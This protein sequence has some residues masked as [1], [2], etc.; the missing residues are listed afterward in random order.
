[1]FSSLFRPSIEKLI[2]KKDVKG[3]ISALK[4][5]DQKYVISAIQALG[6][7]K[8][9]ESIDAL[10]ETWNN[11]KD[12]N[13]RKEIYI[14][15]GKI[16]SEKAIDILGSILD[17]GYGYFQDNPEFA[18]ISA[19]YLIESASESAIKILQT[20]AFQHTNPIVRAEIMDMV[21]IAQKAEFLQLLIYA[22]TDRDPEMT[23][24]PSME[25]YYDPILKK[26]RTKFMRQIG[27][28]GI[29]LLGAGIF[30]KFDLLTRGRTPTPYSLIAY[31]HVLKNIGGEAGMETIKACSESSQG[32]SSVKDSAK[33]LLASVN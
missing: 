26:T 14:S 22:M 31:L 8:A 30:E 6:D 7:I 19:K 28:N 29:T 2:E 10:K 15:L 9:E 32:D 33:K 5:T 23:V 18:L 13:V 4:S 3:L 21:G 16:G 1:M 24:S 12:I 20:I 17:P 25:P 11:S 27:I